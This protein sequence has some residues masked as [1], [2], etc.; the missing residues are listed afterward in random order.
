MVKHNCMSFIAKPRFEQNSC[1][2]CY[3][4]PTPDV[5]LRELYNHER[6][7]PIDAYLLHGCVAMHNNRGGG[8]CTDLNIIF[9]KTSKK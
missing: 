6:Y 8:I 7:G 2:G 4:Y 3:W 9:V 5:M 1:K